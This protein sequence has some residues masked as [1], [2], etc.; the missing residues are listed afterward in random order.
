MMDI[1]VEKQGEQIE[2]LGD[3]DNIIIQNGWITVGIS[4]CPDTGELVIKPIAVDD[5]EANGF[6]MN[7]EGE[8]RLT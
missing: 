3:V 4:V 7:V 6:T 2:V 5:Q 8:V 1:T